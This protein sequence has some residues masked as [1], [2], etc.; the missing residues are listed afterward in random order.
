MRHNLHV[1]Y[2]AVGRLGRSDRSSNGWGSITCPA[3]APASRARRSSIIADLPAAGP[4]HA[5]RRSTPSSARRTSKRTT[6]STGR[7]GRSTLGL[8]D[9]QDTLYGQGLN[10]A[11]GTLSGLRARRP[12][13]T[14][15]IAPVQDVR[16]AVQQ[17]DAAAPERDLGL[18]RQGHGLRQLR[19]AT[20]RWP[21][22]CRAP[23]RGIATSRRPSST[24]TS[25]PTATCSPSIRSPLRP[26]SC[27]CR[28]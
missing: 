9:S 27:S 28:T 16:S 20:T 17:A 4:R 22:R 23:R 13:T 7:T 3:A 1:G 5:C 14:S 18:Q 25:T 26:A 21:A 2:H 12:A 24:P 8:L 19:A 10:N 11:D 6:P 15:A